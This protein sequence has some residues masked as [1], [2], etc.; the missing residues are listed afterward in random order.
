[1]SCMNWSAISKRW[2]RWR[3]FRRCW[4][5]LGTVIGMVE[6]FTE[7]TTAGCRQ[8][9]CACRW[10]CT[11]ADHDGGGPDCRDS[12]SLIGYRYYRSRVDTLVVDME[13]EAIKLVEALQ[14]RTDKA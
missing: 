12:S 8:P 7:I 1:M 4:G 9:G 6:V 14:R 5:L 11:G 3:P 10:Y 13:K 2:V